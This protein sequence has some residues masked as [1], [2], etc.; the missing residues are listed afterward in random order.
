MA[1]FHAIFNGLTATPAEQTAPPVFLTFAVL[2]YHF[3]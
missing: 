1:I 2:Y 3:F